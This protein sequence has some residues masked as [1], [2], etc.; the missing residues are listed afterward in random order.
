MEFTLSPEYQ[1]EQGL[2][3]V[4]GELSVLYDVDRTNKTSEVQV[5]DGYF[6]HFFAPE[7]LPVMPKHIIFVLDVSGSMNGPKLQR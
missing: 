7:N 3:G 1:R 6:V 5:V 4:Q 2:E